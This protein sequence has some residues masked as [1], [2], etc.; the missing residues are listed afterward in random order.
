ML[1]IASLEAK[2]YKE[3]IRMTVNILEGK[4]E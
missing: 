4:D 3:A 2:N 1:Y